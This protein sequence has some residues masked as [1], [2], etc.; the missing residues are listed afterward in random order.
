MALTK[1][2]PTIPPITSEDRAHAAGAAARLVARLV[3]AKG[4]A[5]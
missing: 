3:D 1:T 2:S 4:G 5:R